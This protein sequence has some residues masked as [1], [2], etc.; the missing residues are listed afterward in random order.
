MIEAGKYLL[1]CMFQ[2]GHF[3]KKIPLIIEEKV[4]A[5]VE[6]FLSMSYFIFNE[7]I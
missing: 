4:L 3:R 5:E 2:L 7:I 6:R 1:T